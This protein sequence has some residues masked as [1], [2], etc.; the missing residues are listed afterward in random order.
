MEYRAAY[1]SKPEVKQARK[2]YNKKRA[3]RMSALKNALKGTR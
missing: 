2:D 1:N 3:A